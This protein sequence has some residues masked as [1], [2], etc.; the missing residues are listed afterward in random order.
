MTQAD[1]LLLDTPAARPCTH[2]GR[3]R[4][5]TRQA[6]DQDRCR[7]LGCRKAMSTYR[8]R[9]A[10]EQAY[11]RWSVYADAAPVREHLQ[12]LITAG[13][14]EATIAARAEI[15]CA[16]VRGILHGRGG[17][18]VTRVYTRTARMLLAVEAGRRRTPHLADLLTTEAT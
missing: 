8:R 6:Y 11:G 16:T 12:G 7:C 13:L 5:G 10:K 18:P 2:G 3:H 9:I 15:S 17:Q 1:E 4:H 14:S